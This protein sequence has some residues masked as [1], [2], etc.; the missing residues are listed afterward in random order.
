MACYSFYYKIKND[1][2]LY[3]GTGYGKDE[4]E[5]FADFDYWHKGEDY[6][7]ESFELYK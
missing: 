7:I 4:C 1:D 5:A 3:V 6:E 2:T